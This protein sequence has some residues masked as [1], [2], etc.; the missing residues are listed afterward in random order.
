MKL[1]DLLDL[2]DLNREINDGYVSA[3]R[4][5][6]DPDLMILSYTKQA[7]IENRWNDITKK[8]RGIIA[9]DHGGGDIE[10]IAQPFT[11]FFNYGWEIAGE[12]DLDERVIGF[13]KIDGSLGILYPDP[14]KG[15]AIA[16]RGSFDSEQAERGTQILQR[17]IAEGFEPDPSRTY[18]FEIIYPE[19]RI[20]LDYGDAEKLVLLNAGKTDATNPNVI[21]LGLPPTRFFETPA[22]TP[23]MTLR[24]MIALPD[25]ENAEGMVLHFVDRDPVAMVKLKQEDYLRLHRVVFGFNKRSVWEA[26]RSGDSLHDLLARVPEEVR[27]WLNRTWWELRDEYRAIDHSAFEDWGRIAE[28]VWPF[29]K[30]PPMAGSV[31][32]EDRKRVAE[33]ALKTDYPGLIFLIL[34]EDFGKLDEA[35]YDLIR[36]S[37]ELLHARLT[38]ADVELAA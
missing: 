15:W 8:C 4:H 29:P 23:V 26:M 9:R 22:T 14:F 33:L 2:N 6:A 5:P 7:H 3:R 31:S 21:E 38:K 13:D 25:R 35:I 17:Y 18:L 10:V 32:R 28:T 16:S 1:G 12:F 24:E 20:V 30:T 37:G 36:P 27:K 34:D 11:K 19:N